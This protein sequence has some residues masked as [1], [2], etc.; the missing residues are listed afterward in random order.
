MAKCFPLRRGTAGA[1]AV[2]KAI[3]STRPFVTPSET[4]RQ[5][6]AILDTAVEGVIVIDHRG[7]IETFNRAAQ[8]MFG[9]KA[10]EI[11]GRNVSILMPEPYR[12]EHDGYLSNY[13]RTGRAKIIGIGREAV[14]K[15]KDGKTFPIELAVSEV[16]VGQRR[17]FAGIVR[18]IS[19]RKQLERE[20]LEASERE[21]RKIGHDLHDGLCQELAG[22]AFLVQSMQ[23]SL[24]ASGT[25][26]PDQAEQVTRLL[27]DAVRHT[28]GLSHG[29]H[30][31]EPQP[32]GLSVALQ[33]LA[34]STTDVFKITCT[35]RSPQPVE[36]QDSSSA[37]HI[38]RIA[39][40]AV[41]D[42]IRHGKA[43]RISIELA[44]KRRAIELKI[45]DN[46]ISL[47]QDGRLREDKVLWMMEHRA[48]VIGAKLH[49]KQRSGGVEIR[50]E[51]P[52]PAT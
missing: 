4:E 8:R 17:T 22:I 51:I 26:A 24:E 16:R 32:N 11:I 47:S 7:V 34:D 46:G 15:R 2:A 23:L 33:A 12:G 37:T 44:R 36:M 14:G 27:Q 50:C 3:R 6:H 45:L 1:K 48:R 40:E 21:Q 35:F 25:R 30:P 20:I 5:L 49:V 38:Y 18:D 42:A 19:E 31:V 10:T 13:L 39:Q 41:R 52:D 29:L 28:R 43:T 9:Y